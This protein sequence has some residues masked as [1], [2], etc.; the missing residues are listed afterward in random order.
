MLW[1]GEIGERVGGRPVDIA[2][3]RAEL[4]PAPLRR[5]GHALAHVVG[6]DGPQPTL[7]ARVRHL[8]HRRHRRCHARRRRR[9]ASR[10]RARPLWRAGS[11]GWRGCW[12][13]SDAR[14]RRSTSGGYHPSG[15]R[16]TRLAPDS[17]GSGSSPCAASAS[18]RNSTLPDGVGKRRSAKGTR[19]FG[20]D[21]ERD[22]ALSLQALQRDA[23]E[24]R[25]GRAGSV[26]HLGDDLLG[27]LAQ[28]RLVVAH[29]RSQQAHHVPVALRLAQRRD[30]RRVVLQIAMAVRPYA[31][32]PVRAGWWR[33]ARYRRSA[34]Y[35]S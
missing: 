4:R 12:R 21:I 20:R 35:R 19:G 24:Q 6:D 30:G 22:R 10:C 27:A 34:R 16:Q 2:A 1:P 7:A 9:D 18:Q 13:R 17:S 32:P 25:I 31:D 3:V 26:Q 5:D 15:A 28:P 33:A 14:R 23:F 29:R 8:D 11:A